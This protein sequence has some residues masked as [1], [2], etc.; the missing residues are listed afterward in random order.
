MVLRGL[1]ESAIRWPKIWLGLHT[2]DKADKNALADH[3]FGFS[4]PALKF[5]QEGGKAHRSIDLI[6]EWIRLNAQRAAKLSAFT[7]LVLAIL[8]LAAIA[9]IV[10]LLIL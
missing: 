5:D 9:V 2:G 6:V 1:W 3:D 8:L 7:I 10:V 4:D